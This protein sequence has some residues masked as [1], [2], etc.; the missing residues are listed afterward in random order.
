M[1]AFKFKGTLVY[2]GEVQQI[3]SK[4][5]NIFVKR[6]IGI[7][8]DPDAQYPTVLVGT[9]KK[10]SKRDMTEKVS[11]QD[12][13]KPCI[14][15]FYP[16]GRFYNDKVT[17]AKKAMAGNTITYIEWGYGKKE[18]PDP[19]VPDPAEPQSSIDDVAVDDM[20]F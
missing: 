10:S 9:L 8:D 19:S 18:E 17:G 3:K 13:N 11:A 6:D 12:I 2:V 7:A 15:S 16:D 1:D 4:N 20:P 5:G 14:V